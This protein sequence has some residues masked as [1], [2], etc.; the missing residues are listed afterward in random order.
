MVDINDNKN[1]ECVEDNSNSFVFREKFPVGTWIRRMGSPNYEV[2][3]VKEVF[4]NEYHLIKYSFN[5][6]FHASERFIKEDIGN[7]PI[8]IFDSFFYNKIDK[9]KLINEDPE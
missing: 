5:P 7:Q 1:D 3:Y 8:D 4:E 9:P 6:N 2:F